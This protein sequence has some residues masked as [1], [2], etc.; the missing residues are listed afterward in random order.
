MYKPINKSQHLFL[1]F[2]QLMGLR[3]NSENRWIK[4]A[5]RMFFVF[6]IASFQ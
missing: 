4:M 3:M 5:D 6:A 1:D 2:N